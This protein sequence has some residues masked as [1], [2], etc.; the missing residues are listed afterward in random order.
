MKE[1][2]LS[3]KKNVFIKLFAQIY[4]FL[5][6]VFSLFA[7]KVGN[8]YRIQ[9]AYKFGYLILVVFMLIHAFII[10]RFN[11]E[12]INISSALSIIPLVFIWRNPIH[13]FLSILI[14][15][16]AFIFIKSKKIKYGALIQLG[17]VTLVISILLVT[18]QFARPY[19][20]VEVIKQ[21]VV[22][23]NGKHVV[24]VIEYENGGSL[25]ENEQNV[26]LYENMKI[27]FYLFYF[28]RLT[29]YGLD[30]GKKG[31]KKYIYWKGNDTVLVNG[32]EYTQATQWGTQ[33]AG[34]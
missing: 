33:G 31:D 13:Y 19:D 34:D 18:M 16:I 20:E 5:I 22:S 17:L 24:E 12:I 21:S 7:F 8:S 6:L 9:S 27:D 11:D 32:T 3:M 10:Y 26:Y 29:Y 25:S 30:N 28:K 2:Y 1:A 4:T 23:P 15:A 14:Y